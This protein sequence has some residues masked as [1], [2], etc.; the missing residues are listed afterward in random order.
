MEDPYTVICGGDSGRNIN[1]AQAQGL[2]QIFR[3]FGGLASEAKG[4]E[5][6]IEAL[7]EFADDT[8][9][10]AVAQSAVDTLRGARIPEKLAKA[11]GALCAGLDRLGDLPRDLRQLAEE[12]ARERFGRRAHLVEDALGL[13]RRAAER[14]VA[15]GAVEEDRR[16]VADVLDGLEELVFG[17]GRRRGGRLARGGCGSGRGR[18]GRGVGVAHPRIVAP[19]GRRG[20]R[21]VGQRQS[22]RQKSTSLLFSR[23]SETLP[24]A[25]SVGSSSTA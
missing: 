3:Y 12:R 15:R 10:L 1:I 21:R 23:H 4:T 13:L 14:R 11:I 2:A 24:L 18:I 20:Q 5:K 6:V 22:G 17:A 16:G 9:D 25:G 19:R 8:T 7:I